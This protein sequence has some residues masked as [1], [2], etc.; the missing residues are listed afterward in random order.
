MQARLRPPLPIVAIALA[1]GAA[2]A[3]GPPA[4]EPVT[5]WEGEA[6]R[7]VLEY[8]GEALAVYATGDF[9]DWSPHP[10]QR[11]GG[12]RWELTLSLPPGEYR[13]LVAVETAG[14]W[15]L[16]PDPANPLR[17]EDARGRSL[18]LLRVGNGNGG[19]D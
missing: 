9:N 7:V 10:Y 17:A 5:T 12:D 16:H 13:Y 1:L 11:M 6:A 19:D 3:C 14:D 8:R 18:S 4:R 2:G 15:S